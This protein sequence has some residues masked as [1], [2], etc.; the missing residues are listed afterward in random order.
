MKRVVKMQTNNINTVPATINKQD[1]ALQ[2]SGT[3]KSFIRRSAQVLSILCFVAIAVLASCD[4]KPRIG[5]LMD[6]L[7]IERWNKDKALFE[8][9]VKELGGVA[10][11]AVADSDPDKQLEQARQMIDEGVDVLVV[12]PVDLE[13]AGEIVKLA[14][15]SYVPVISYDRLIK[16]CNLDY[17]VSTDNINIGELQANYLTKISPQGNYV[18]ISGPT[19]DYNA[20]LLHLGWMNVLQPL[21]D[22]GDI[23]VVLDEFSEFWLPDEAYR[24]LSQY[25]KDKNEVDA[26]ICG[27]DALASGAIAALKEHKKDGRVLLAG[28]DADIQAVRNIVAGYQTITIYKPIESLAFAAAN[29]AIKISDGEAPSN[30]HITVNN[31]KRLVPAILL[32][33]SIVNS[34]NIKMTVI[35]EGYIGEQDIFN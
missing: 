15:Q 9:K 17:Y 11:I 13:K 34:Q 6:S 18:L 16:N 14:H 35:Q 3:A 30:M 31:G 5:F 1:M 26:I 24:I 2:I 27:N 12:V 33:A 29:A 21:I 23:N 25:L 7:E 20:Y 8:E 19:S 28:Q 22:K 32:Q 10:V 4:M